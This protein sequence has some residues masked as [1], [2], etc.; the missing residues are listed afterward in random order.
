VC[1][2]LAAALD[3]SAAER[4]G[5]T[6]GRRRVRETQGTLEW[7]GGRQVPASSAVGAPLLTMRLKGGRGCTGT[8]NS[9]KQRKYRIPT[10][11]QKDA[12]RNR[13]IALSH[14]PC[15]GPKLLSQMERLHGAGVVQQAIWQASPMAPF[16]DPRTVSLRH[17]MR[18]NRFETNTRFKMVHKDLNHCLL[19]ACVRGLSD[20]VPGL[21]DKGAD[22]NF[23]GQAKTGLSADLVGFTPISAAAHQ[24]WPAVVRMLLDLGADQRGGVMDD[25]QYAADGKELWLRIAKAGA[26][27]RARTKAVMDAKMVPYHANNGRRTPGARRTR[28]KHGAV[29]PKS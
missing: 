20:F 1:A 4:S 26:A 18:W 22:I 21:V 14:K 13:P 16:H 29:R 28:V 8:R 23:L 24:G 15:S 2:L 11:V 27:K 5:Q 6:A 17:G 12:K 10:G 19:K 7:C 9:V 25:P 3:H